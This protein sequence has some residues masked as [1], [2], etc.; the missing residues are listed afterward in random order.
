MGD[1]LWRI[2]L[3]PAGAAG[4]YLGRTRDGRPCLVRWLPQKRCFGA[5]GFKAQHDGDVL[6]DA[7]MLR[8][9]GFVVAHVPEP[10]AEGDTDPLSAEHRS[11]LHRARGDTDEDGANAG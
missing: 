4:T 9:G 2:G 1:T 3:P 5:V 8:G 6:P 11:A 10:L 7:M